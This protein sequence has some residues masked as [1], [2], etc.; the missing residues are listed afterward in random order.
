MSVILLFPTTI[1]PTNNP[2]YTRMAMA[3]PNA[4]IVLADALRLDCA[5]PASNRDLK[6]PNLAALA[7]HGLSFTQAITQHP[8]APSARAT[9]LTGQYPSTH[10]ETASSPGAP[11][12]RLPRLL[13][14]A[15]YTTAVVGNTQC[16]VD[17]EEH[18]F[19]SVRQMGTVDS[20]DDD[21]A[22]WLAQPD[23]A[24]RSDEER[25][26]TAWIGSQAIRFLQSTQEPFFL[27]VC[28]TR[29]QPPLDP[30]PPWD[31]TYDPLALNPPAHLNLSSTDSDVSREDR[32][33]LARYY[34]TIS[35]MD[36]QIGRILATVAGRGHTNNMIV[37]TSD[38]GW[39]LGGDE[40]IAAGDPPHDALLRIPLIVSGVAGQRHGETDDSPV[41]LADVMPTVIDAAGCALPPDI[42]GKS[43]LPVLKDSSVR[44]RD[45]AYAESS[46]GIRLLRTR[47]HKLVEFPYEE[48]RSLYDLEA[49]PDETT[50][51][52]GNPQTIGEQVKLTRLLRRIR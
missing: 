17:P 25:S 47:R 40:R 50:N 2:F 1:D 4:I 20:N 35:H 3:Q 27:L 49:D 37:F 14:D 5:P 52:L 12:V 51:L 46:N 23:T 44:H 43:F 19:T 13:R 28:F 11:S 30:P 18:G 15:G 39:A 21:Y 34:A 24:K 32:I 16:D 22:A 41:E 29:P 8:L 42:P 10:G 6:T 45:A 26:R 7:K 33:E 48:R 38:R 36:S 31:A 9:L